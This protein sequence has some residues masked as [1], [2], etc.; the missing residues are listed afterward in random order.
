MTNC[1]L[2]AFMHGLER[3][4]AP[5]TAPTQSAFSCGSAF[6]HLQ[7]SLSVCFIPTSALLPL[8]SLAFLSQP[9]PPVASP[10]LWHEFAEGRSR[11]VS[12]T[13][14]QGRARSLPA[15]CGLLAS[16]VALARC[17]PGPTAR[18][19]HCRRLPGRA[20]GRVPDGCLEA[21]IA[22]DRTTEKWHCMTTQKPTGRYCR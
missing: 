3:V 18:Q 12:V 4:S 6:S 19:S 7:A 2:R 13:Q 20:P 9:D 5:C 21:A 17:L 8:H 1:E 11:Q 14:A 16:A 10:S 15:P 22:L